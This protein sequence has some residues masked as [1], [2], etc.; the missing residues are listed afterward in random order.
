[1][2]L[3][4]KKEKDS[5]L[6]DMLINDNL[7][8]KELE[9]NGQTVNEDEVIKTIKDMAVRNNMTYESLSAVRKRKV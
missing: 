6:L 7:I 3:E 4:T 1:M 8:Q 5:F 2:S 9:K